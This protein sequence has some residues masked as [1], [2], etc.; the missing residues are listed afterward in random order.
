MD[1]TANGSTPPQYACPHWNCPQPDVAGTGTSGRIDVA[2]IKSVEK[3]ALTELNWMFWNMNWTSLNIFMF[4]GLPEAPTYCPV[5]VIG[6]YRTATGMGCSTA[7]VN[8]PVVSQLTTSATVTCVLSG[9]ATMTDIFFSCV[10][11]GKNCTKLHPTAAFA[12]LATVTF[13]PLDAVMV[14]G[15]S[16]SAKSVRVKDFRSWNMNG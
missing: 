16:M 6:Q 15:S 10:D 5:P 13:V 11:A 8:V 7:V 3:L 2:P 1:D 9:I 4:P 12:L 14:I